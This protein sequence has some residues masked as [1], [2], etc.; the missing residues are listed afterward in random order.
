MY[1]YICNLNKITQ[2]DNLPIGLKTLYC[3]Y[4]YI[5]Q[6]NNLPPGLKTLNCSNNQI[7]NLDN[8]P[9]SLEILV[10]FNDKIKQLDNL[11]SGLQQLLECGRHR[12]VPHSRHPYCRILRPCLVPD[13]LGAAYVSSAE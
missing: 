2:L 10:C 6:L 12:P 1:K 7:T 5:T 11:P 9:S 13:A 8:L 4:N 3:S